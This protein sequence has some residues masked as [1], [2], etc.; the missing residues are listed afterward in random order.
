LTS[1]ELIEERNRA[2]RPLVRIGLALAHF[3][4][5]NRSYPTKLSQLVPKYCKSIPQDPFAERPFRYRKTDDGY[6]LY[7]VGWNRRDDGGKGF[8]NE[9]ESD[10]LLIEV[11][12][13]AK[14]KPTA[15]NSGD[16]PDTASGNSKE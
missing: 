16:Q 7:S 1:S 6:R 8:N 3:H 10:D 14:P 12:L 2:Y 15:A 4:A 9:D 11:P 13:K 5:E